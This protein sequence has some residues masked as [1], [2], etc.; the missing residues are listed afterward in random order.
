VQI[1]PIGRIEADPA[2]GRAAR[3]SQCAA[4][5]AQRKEKAR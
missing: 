1:S 5:A 3:E 2:A 4:S